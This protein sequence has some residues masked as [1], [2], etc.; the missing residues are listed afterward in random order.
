MSFNSGIA[1]LARH[2]DRTVQQKAISTAQFGP[3][4]FEAF[5]SQS[6]PGSTASYK[7]YVILTTGNE[8]GSSTVV[9]TRPAA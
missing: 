6:N 7:V 8:S 3:K 1:H 4:S 2:V 5:A 9:I